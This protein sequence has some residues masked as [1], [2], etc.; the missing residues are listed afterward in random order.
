MSGLVGHAMYAVLGLRAAIEHKLPLARVAQQHFPNFVAGSYIGSDI[1]TMP[2]AICVDTGREVGYG[3]VPVEKSPITGG[4]VRPF[5][6]PTPDGDLRP[7]HVHQRFYGRAHLVFGFT[8]REKTLHVPWDHLPDYFA[9]VIDDTF[10]LY[11]PGEQ[12]LAY[13]LG[14]MVH[15]VGDSLIKGIQP[16]INLQLIDGR[17]TARNRPVQDLVTFHEVGS[18]ELLIDWPHLFADVAATPIEPVQLHYMRCAQSRGH[19]AQLFTEGWTP[20]SEATLRAVLAENRRW[21][22]HHADDV[23]ADMQLDHGEANERLRSLANMNYAQMVEAAEAAGFRQT[24]AQIADAVVEMFIATQQLCPRLAQ[25]RK[26]DVAGDTAFLR[27]WQKTN[28]H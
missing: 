24:L 20:S 27:P 3:T 17:Y 21:L 14:W 13:V 26:L 28:A 9:A 7:D 11:G 5:L 18:K 22:K 16:G 10:D 6:L 25:L 19:L 8:V 1:Q 4:A 15:V 12:A 2:E 23:L